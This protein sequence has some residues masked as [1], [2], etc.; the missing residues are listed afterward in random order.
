MFCR[1]DRNDISPELSRLIRRA[2]NPAPVLRAMGTVFKSITEGN[3]NEAGATDRPIPWKAKQDGS[4]SNLQLTRTLS[5]SFHMEVSAKTVTVSN[6]M[7]YAAIHQFGGVIVPK[8]A[9]SL[10][11]TDA[12]GGK[13]FAKR[14][15]MPARPFFPVLNGKLTQH[16]ESLIAA[17]GK[18]AME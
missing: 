3:F 10:M 1:L 9:K 12:A 16:A 11:W 2:R 13:H 6:P 18:R 15:T 17:A 8:N 14:V 5:R 4:P 7:I